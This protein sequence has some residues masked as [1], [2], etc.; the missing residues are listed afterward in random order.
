MQ[1]P[2]AEA[3]PSQVQFPVA[4]IGP[5]SKPADLFNM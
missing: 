4:R 2:G 3:A 5:P 1:E